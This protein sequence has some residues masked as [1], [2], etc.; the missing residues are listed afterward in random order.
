MMELVKQNFG[1]KEHFA[2]AGGWKI[3][4][5]YQDIQITKL[6]GGRPQKP[7]LLEQMELNGTMIMTSSQ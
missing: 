6:S 5:A 7:Y 2:T 3:D 1:Q 4:G